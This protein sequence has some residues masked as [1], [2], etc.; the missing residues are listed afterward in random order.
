[1]VGPLAIASILAG[2]VYRAVDATTGVTS[3]EDRYTATAFPL[4]Q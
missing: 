4:P 1:M 3:P 2:G